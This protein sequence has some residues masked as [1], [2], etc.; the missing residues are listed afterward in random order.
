M[1]HIQFT[2]IRKNKIIKLGVKYLFLMK[3]T[4]LKLK[5][6][7]VKIQFRGAY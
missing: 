3:S 5:S 6:K 1:L 4:S 7:Y 2:N